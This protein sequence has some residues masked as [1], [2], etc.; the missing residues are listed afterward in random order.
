MQLKMACFLS[1]FM[2][3]IVSFGSDEKPLSP[4]LT[5]EQ[6][7]FF[8]KKIRPVLAEHCYQCHSAK[9]E[10]DGQLKGGLALDSREAS[11]LGGDSGPAVV[12]G[13]VDESL[14]IEAV[15]YDT[16]KMPPKGKLPQAVIADLEQWIRSGAPDPRTAVGRTGPRKIDI[17][18]GRQFWSYRPVI[19]TPVPEVQNQVW[20]KGNIDRFILSRLE[21]KRLSPAVDSDR[22]T[23]IRRLYFDLIGLPPTPSQIDA[24]VND[25]STDA[26]EKLVNQ[27]LDS[28]HF[29]ERWGRHWLDVVR[30]AE[31]LTLRGFIMP[32]A[33]RYRDY[34][35]EAMNHDR[36]FS[37]FLREQ[38]AGDLLPA[39]SLADRQRQVIATSF[40]VLGNTN[41]EEQDKVQLRMDVVDEQLDVISKGI[42]AQTVTC[43]RC[44]DHKF[45][46]IPTHDY[47]AIAGILRNTKVL[48]HANVSK[49][50]EFPLPVEPQQEAIFKKHESELD[51]LQTRLK[52]AKD[53]LKSLTTSKTSGANPAV[54]AAKDLPG[55]VVDSAQAKQVGEWKLSQF[56]K[57]YIGD[58]YLHDLDQD[59]GKK[60]LTFQPELPKAGL[61]EVRLAYSAGESRSQDAPVTIFSADGEKTVNVNEQ[62]LPP[63]DARF[64]SLGEFRFEQNGQGFVIVS[65]EGTRGHVTADAVQFLAKDM[66]ETPALNSPPNAQAAD[67]AS[68]EVALIKQREL[69][70]KR[71]EDE[72]KTLTET[73][74][75]RPMYMSI[76][77]EKDITDSPIHIRGTVHN[78]GEVAPRGFLQV[79]SQ[80]TTSALPKDSSGRRELADW[81]ASPQNPLTARVFANRTWHWLLG[82]G[83][84]RTTD[85]FGTTGELPSHPELLDYLAHEFVSHNWS[86]KTLIRQI[87]L[88]RT[89]QLSTE[90]SPQLK[91]GDPDNL[92]F[93]R[94]I[95]KR[96][97]AESILDALLAAGGDLDLRVGGSNIRP[98]TSSDFGYQFSTNRRAVYWPVFRNAL[99]DLFEVFDYPDPSMVVGSRNTSTVAPQ[100]LFLLN[101]PFVHSQAQLA[102]TRLLRETSGQT[103][104]EKIRILFRQL[105]GRNPLLDEA[106]QAEK[107][108]TQGNATG[109]EI[110]AERWTGLVHVIFGTMDFR[111]TN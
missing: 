105:L 46:P 36:P 55:I 93:G 8:E 76:Q 87:V 90:T 59:K 33:W 61:Y 78:L 102:A 6:T 45:D 96:L 2:L 9:A 66:T 69:D 49:W 40:L 81:L 1:C 71:L 14:L 51:A 53:D 62:V 106:Q 42:L 104:S 63:I 29:G 108:L 84:V 35:I 27:L 103:T 85:N 68:V 98:G 94:A 64:V 16:L 50:L 58:G 82:H 32:E 31:S 75:K 44:H 25:S 30:F 26:Y 15:R 79:A 99:P 65:N 92:L 109:Q 54:I 10:A 47:Y 18:A 20:P 21:A 17:E 39:A 24:F 43:A 12:P 110:S 5:A 52:T 111:Y 57:R 11:Q 38:I 19:R 86:P 3:S 37:Q 34:V 48:E 28:P 73:T 80:G 88:S 97:D 91:S 107:F 83:I 67:A 7:D 72:I 22:Q 4:P 70:I 89:Y 13:Q 95:R 23:L 77:E 100:A 60:S 41:L 101:N 56:S 74:P